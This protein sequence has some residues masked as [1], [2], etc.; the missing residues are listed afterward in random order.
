MTRE[1][2]RIDTSEE[3]LSPEAIERALEGREAEDRAR[4][5]REHLDEHPEARAALEKYR[6]IGEGKDTAPSLPPLAREG[7]GRSEPGG[8]TVE[9]SEQTKR[10][11]PV[12]LAPLV[13]LLLVGG[14]TLMVMKND[15]G[16]AEVTSASAAPS[17]AAAAS[18]SASPTPQP[19]PSVTTAPIVE[20]TQSADAVRTDRPKQTPPPEVST[21]PTAPPTATAR[22]SGGLYF[23][24]KE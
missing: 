4:A 20:P 10:R 24:S 6:R 17:A 23:E 5:F 12:L 13:L 2:G 14:V 3:L 16:P 11:W 15:G 7:R 21:K 22:A 8:V 18:E 1:R 9:Q 19:P